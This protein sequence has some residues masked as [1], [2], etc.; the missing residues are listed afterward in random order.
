MHTNFFL[1]FLL[2]HWICRKLPCFGV[3]S[4]IVEFLLSWKKRGWSS[5]PYKLLNSVQFFVSLYLL[6]IENI[7]IL[8]AWYKST[9]LPSCLFFATVIYL[10]CSLFYLLVLFIGSKIIWDWRKKKRWSPGSSY[11][12]TLWVHVLQRQWHKGTIYFLQLCHALITYIAYLYGLEHSQ[13]LSHSYMTQSAYS[14]ELEHVFGG[15]KEV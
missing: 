3:V 9:C 12:K 1:L 2:F 6:N 11:W 7:C 10:K 8:S 4:L 14:C 13:S 5:I 15:F